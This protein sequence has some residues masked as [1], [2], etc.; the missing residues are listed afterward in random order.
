METKSNLRNSQ[1]SIIYVWREEFK[2]CLLIC[3]HLLVVYF[4]I[5]NGV[6]KDSPH[7]DTAVVNTLNFNCRPIID[8]FLTYFGGLSATA[9]SPKEHK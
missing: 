3:V 7:S 5:Q 2:Q 1:G 4:V 9:E 8:F 6:D